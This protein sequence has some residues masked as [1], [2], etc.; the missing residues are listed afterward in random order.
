MDLAEL[1]AALSQPGAYRFPA[2]EVVVCQTHISV[3]FLA[4]SFAYKIKKP[5]KLSFVDFSTLELRRH[6]CDE[7]VRLNRRLAP[8][9]YLGVVPV[10][11][12]GSAVQVEGDGEL[13]DWAVK[14]ER[15]PAEATL[16]ERLRRN[17]VGDEAITALARTI[18]DFHRKAEANARIAAFGRFEAV[19]RNIRENFTEWKPEGEPDRANC[20]RVRKLMDDALL[21]AGSLIEARA[22]RGVPRDLHGDLRLDHSYLFPDR[23]PPEDLVIV[24]CIE[25]T[26]RFRFIDPVADMAFLVMDLR[27]AGR[28]DLADA[29]AAAY[30][31]ASGDDEGRQLLTLYTAYRASVRAKVEGIKS[32]AK[33]VP[34]GERATSLAESRAHSL[35]ALGELETPGR[36]PCLLL[37][38]GLPGAGKS[39]LATALAER[40]GLQIIRTDV[41]RKEIAVG[42]ADLYT[43]EWIHRTYEECLRRAGDVVAGGGRVLVDANFRKECE[44]LPF[45]EAGAHWG[46]PVL[47]LYCQASPEVVRERLAARRGDA[48]DADWAVYCKLAPEWEPP[49]PVVRRIWAVV[50]MDGSRAEALEQALASLRQ[51]GLADA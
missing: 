39:T 42:V 40:C 15:L 35:L 50:N 10:T 13:V 5:V 4:G 43:P 49:G 18:A 38:A 51:R 7:E 11:R 20:E 47:T 31:Q 2:D 21:Q 24:D 14:M 44:R 37:T 29:F 8:N 1:I 28:R 23:P 36:R 34:E 32:A 16:R 6:Y 25:F 48:S 41:V 30:F 33:E 19:A 12:V 3:V 45:L 17:E 26:E 22:L 9:V 46:V 27:R